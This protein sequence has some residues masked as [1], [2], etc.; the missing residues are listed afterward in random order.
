MSDHVRDVS[1]ISDLEDWTVIEQSILVH[2]PSWCIDTLLF[3]FRRLFPSLQ[4]VTLDDVF[5]E[6]GGMLTYTT[7][8][9]QLAILKVGL[10]MMEWK[11]GFLM[12]DLSIQ[13]IRLGTGTLAAK[14]KSS[15]PGSITWLCTCVDGGT[16]V[17]VRYQYEQPS[18]YFEQI[19]E[20][21]VVRNLITQ[22]LAKTLQVVKQMAEMRAS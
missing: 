8:L 18:Q 13:A 4:D 20:Q 14:S 7:R 12:A 2:A 19:I 1:T 10:T 6:I 11:R 3:D 16:R 22:H 15:T 5:P 21:R 17:T 9:G